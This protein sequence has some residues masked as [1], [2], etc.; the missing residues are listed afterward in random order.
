MY[1]KNIIPMLIVLVTACLDNETDN[2][3]EPDIMTRLQGTW[4]GATWT[5][6]G[7]FCPPNV[8]CA[9]NYSLTISGDSFFIDIS[10][11]T[12]AIPP[13]AD[14]CNSHQWHDYAAGIL[15]ATS[16]SLTFSGIYTDSTYSQRLQTSCHPERKT[17]DYYYVYTYKFKGDTLYL[18]DYIRLTGN[19]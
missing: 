3:N 4:H 14:S 18:G 9:P 1:L 15:N 12:N 16:D 5:T 11:A 10:S 8:P 19:H 13:V 7:G 17:G 6:S 2:L